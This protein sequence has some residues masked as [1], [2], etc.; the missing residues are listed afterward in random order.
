MDD[1]Q[2]VRFGALGPT[3]AAYPFRPGPVEG[4]ENALREVVAEFETHAYVYTARVWVTAQD[5][6]SGRALV[7]RREQRRLHVV[8]STPVADR[9]REL[10]GAGFTG[11]GLY[12]VQD[13]WTLLEIAEP[14]LGHRA[15]NLLTREGFTT[16]E[17]LAATPDAGLLDL[18]NL[19]AKSLTAIHDAVTTYAGPSLARPSELLVQATRRAHIEI[20]LSAEHRSRNAEFLAAL[21]R[22]S[23][24]LEA[25]DAILASLRTE[26]L[27]PVDDTVALLLLTAAEPD[28]A[29]LYRLPRRPRQDPI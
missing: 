22:S 6:D 29:A 16:I 24:P 18:R 2:S 14:I 28:L 23:V 12:P 9:V 20:G 8:G 19:G 17:E 7:F 21:S 25:V 26:P 4:V 3:S 13:G 10:L 15:Y 27:P 1:D 5:G 11:W